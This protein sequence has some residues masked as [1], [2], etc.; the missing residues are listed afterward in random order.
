MAR[1]T[2]P[3]FMNWTDHYEN[4]EGFMAQGTE[5]DRW[6]LSERDSKAFAAT[7]ADLGA[8]LTD[9]VIDDAVR[10]LP[11]EWYAI[12]GPSLTAALQKR[13]DTLPEAAAEYYARLARKVDVHATD[14]DDVARVRRQ[15]DGALE[16][17]IATSPAAEPWFRR[18]FDPRETDEVRLYLYGGA[19]RVVTEGPSGGPITLR[20][21]GG[22]G[23]D[24]LDDSGSGGT[25]YYDFEG[26]T[27]LT[28]GPGTH[29]DGSSWKRRPAKPE[30]TP[31]LEW[32]D[33]GQRTLP[34][35]QLWWEP[36]PGAHA[37]GRAHAA[38]VGLPQVS[39]REPAVGP[40]AVQ[41]RA[42]ELQVQLRRRVPKG[43]LE[44][45][46]RGGRAGLGP[47]EPQLLRHGQRLVR[48]SAG[49]P[50]RRLLRR[51]LGHLP[52]HRRTEVEP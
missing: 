49:G 15:P 13:R 6:L 23:A 46:P 26:K 48:G 44:P 37:R 28:K 18:T 42:A 47:R 8:R 38:D 20:V 1:A 40:A 50:G 31:W 29:A 35:F 24:A 52:A 14:A 21:V 2:H 34:A 3:K 27:T 11:E 41:H 25:R 19:D 10:R 39:L 4:F 36:D 7:A 12:D 45:L 30:E 32:R 43:E 16:L 33:W 17:E 9:A 51:R 22:P 5:V